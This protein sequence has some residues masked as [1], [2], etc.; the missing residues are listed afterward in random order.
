MF[1]CDWFDVPP[2]SSDQST[3]TNRKK[4]DQSRGYKKDK[5]GI[6]DIDTTVLRYKDDPYILGIQ[7]EQVFYVRDVKKPNWSTVVKMKPRNLFTMPTTEI[8][9]NNTEVDIDSFDIGVDEMNVSS[10]NEDVTSWGRDG[11]EGVSGDACALETFQLVEHEDDNIEDDD[12]DNDDETYVN[13][14]HVAPLA[15]TLDDD[16]FFI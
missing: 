15:H 12:E 5:Y 16:D 1:K 7:A 14:G 9:D 4:K 11:L 10:L 3:T 6:V 2:P 8:D 13:D